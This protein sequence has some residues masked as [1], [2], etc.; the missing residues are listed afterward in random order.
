ML[1][2]EIVE[3]ITW[4]GHFSFLCLSIYIFVHVLILKKL[5]NMLTT[6]WLKFEKYYILFFILNFFYIHTKFNLAF[7]FIFSLFVIFILIWIWINIC[8]P[9]MCK[10]CGSLQYFIVGKYNLDNYV[11][12]HSTITKISNWWESQ[13]EL[14]CSLQFYLISSSLYPPILMYG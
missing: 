8:I 12:Y 13:I 11:N 10:T 3:Y 1:N 14:L 6:H 4:V 7:V 2:C 5:I 9:I